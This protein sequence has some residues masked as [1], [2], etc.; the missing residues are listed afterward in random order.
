MTLQSNSDARKIDGILWGPGLI[1]IRHRSGRSFQTTTGAT[2]TQSGSRHA[3][4][5]ASVNSCALA[6]GAAVQ[7]WNELLTLWLP[8]NDEEHPAGPVHSSSICEIELLSAG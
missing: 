6:T 1:K 3:V 5:Q 2:A 4:A 7:L 8:H